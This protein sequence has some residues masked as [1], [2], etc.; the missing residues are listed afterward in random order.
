NKIGNAF[1]P[2]MLVWFTTIGVLGF[3]HRYWG[4]PRYLKH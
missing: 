1:G 3:T 4:R 2:I